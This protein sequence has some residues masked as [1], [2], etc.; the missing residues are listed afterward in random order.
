MAPLRPLLLATALVLAGGP[1]GAQSFDCSKAKGA[2]EAAICA[3]PALAE[4]DRALLDAYRAALAR[5]PARA[6]TIRAE[7]R[8]WAANREAVCASKGEPPPRI[9][10][11]LAGLYR[12]RL[13]T[14]AASAVPPAPAGTPAPPARPAAAGGVPGLAA[15][16]PGPGRPAV[17]PSPAT[18]PRP[19]LVG[20]PVPPLP[21]PPLPALPPR[22]PDPAARLDRDAVA[23][24]GRSDALLTVTSPGR[25]AIRAESRTGVSLQLVDMIAGPGD[26]AGAPGVKDGRVDAL[27]DRGTYKLRVTGAAKAE[28]EA[29]LRVEPFLAAGEA[30]TSLL[31]GGQASTTLADRQSRSFWVAVGASGRVAVEAAGRSLGDLRL[32]RNGRDLADLATRLDRVTPATGHPL[33]RAR[34]EGEVERGLYLATAYGGPKLTWTDGDPGEPLHLRVGAP[35]ALAGLVE[36]TVGPSGTA[37]FAAPSGAASVRLELPEPAAATLRARRGADTRVATL[38]K[39]SREP[40]LALA[41]PGGTGPASLEV[42]AAQG[43]PFRLQALDPGAS[44]RVSG[45]G[46]HWIAVDVAGVGGDEVPATVLLAQSDARAA[47]VI[48]GNAP[49]IGPGQGWRTK[50]NLRGPTTL[51]VEVTGAGPIAV[52]LNGPRSS[53]SFAPLLGSRTPRADGRTPRFDMEPGWYTMKIDPVAGASG[54]ADLT[55]A[56]PGMGVEL[57]AR[58]PPRASVTLGVQ[59]LDRTA[60]YQVFTNAAPGLALAPVARPLPLDLEKGALALDQAAGQAL[61]LPIRWSARG[62]ISALAPNGIPIEATLAYEAASPAGRTATLILPAPD[63]AR[64]VILAWSDPLGAASEVTPI[65]APTELPTVVAGNPRFFNLARGERTSFT[66]DV[67]EG[68]LYRVET[69][70]RLRTALTVATSFLPALDKAEAN[71]AGENALAQTYLRA[72]RYRVV[73]GASESAGRVGLTAR[74]A[75]L[76]EAGRLLPGTSGRAT[77]ADGRGIVFPLEITDAGRYRIELFA[78]GEPF[79]ARIEDHE[80]WPLTAPGPLTSL[81][82]RFE[83]GRYRLVVLPGTVE[84]RAVARL[85]R[86]EPAPELAGHGP[87]PLSFDGEVAFQ[88][89]EPASLGE[90]RHP[91]GWTFRLASPAEVT[92]RLGEGMAGDLRREG[93]AEP[94]ARIVGKPGFAGRLP[95]GRYLLEARALGRNDRLDYTV[96]LAASEIQP[97]VPRRVELPAT[98]S[99]AVAEDRVVTLTTFGRTD[100]KGVLKDQDGRVIER[101]TDR[102]DDWNIGLSRR[103][104]AGSYRLELSAVQPKAKPK[105]EEA[106]SASNDE[107]GDD[108]ESP[109]GADEAA[110]EGAGSDAQPGADAADAPAAAEASPEV[111]DSEAP[112]DDRVEV[113]LALPDAAEMPGLPADGVS[114]AEGG[115]VHLA[116]VPSAEAGTLLLAAARSSQEIVLALERREPGGRWTVVGTSRGLAP[117]VA[118]TADGDASRPWRL[119]AWAVDG[120]PARIA[121]ALRTVRRDSVPA[122]AVALAPVPLGEVAEDVRVA[123][124][125]APASGV[126]SLAE[127]PAGLL[128]GSAAGRAL[129]PAE[130]VLVPQSE[131]VWLVARGPARSLKLAAAPLPTAPVALTVPAGG[132]AVLPHSAPPDGRIR[133]WRAASAFGQ[134]GLEAGRGMGLAAGS[135]VAVAGDAPLRAWNAEGDVPLSLRLVARDLA[136]AP[137]KPASDEVALSVAAGTAQ[138]LRLAAGRK[139]LRLDLAPGTVVALAGPGGAPATV[140]ADR[141]A[142]SRTLEGEWTSLVLAN[143][144][145]SAQPVRASVAPSAADHLALGPETVVKRFFGAA[146]SL[147]LPVDARPGD[148]LVAVGA[149]VSFLGQDGQVLRGR[150]LAL[151]GPGEA[152]LDHPPGLVALWI[153]RAGASPWPKAEPRSVE[154]PSVT[155]LDGPAMTLA[156]APP[157]PVLLH[158]RTSAPAILRLDGGEPAVFPAGAELHRLIPA[159]RS[160]LRLDS[161]HDGPLAGAL[162]LT[163]TPVTPMRDG[164]GEAV[165]LAPGGTALFAFELSRRGPVGIGI[166]AEPDVAAVRLLDAGGRELGRGIAQLHTLDPGRY[167]LEAS[168]PADGRTATL[169]PAVIGIAPPPSGP[170]PDVVAR[171]LELVGLAPTAPSR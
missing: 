82:R 163:A 42:T 128:E 150:S 62:G 52:G 170:P 77:L 108:P 98:I 78:L 129:A 35:E 140:F 16:I 8:S 93:E 6:E 154:L 38:T 117:L 17:A 72:G 27:L 24:A 104:A 58:Q 137:E 4:Q 123:L 50:F 169:R 111:A 134:P 57:P 132:R 89:R 48:A 97:G 122:D 127:A 115:A 60:N 101:L 160:E 161:P 109:E 32:W 166:R 13:G 51:L 49:K 103:L 148:R 46:P 146:G 86:I 141:E 41:L 149:E 11:C 71:G 36:G 63:K 44:R 138:P 100:L 171:Y 45:A 69:L 22:D 10:A 131:A 120:G 18:P 159:G 20:T 164:V 96:A 145:A 158:A 25:F 81:E 76:P 152:I 139:R 31:R 99:F 119:A 135:A 19:V 157:V 65:P 83:P 73:V 113:R 147:S 9:A 23:A 61:E 125:A 12:T 165:A 2:V 167:L 79:R 94:V 53:V 84:A 92:L 168:L 151:A 15:G 70:G 14:L 29:K 66:V 155:K 143:L 114:V 156:L 91:D 90:P 80:G 3:N 116:P 107:S 124:A 54:I 33:T 118:A 1:A 142:V 7:Q 21:V 87:H 26:E 43:Q 67:P 112:A 133:V 153:E 68:G 121:L 85:T 64:A 136:L 74:P 110:A 144:G 95:A 102:A 34:I 126:L 105:P 130:P 59:V 162:E 39:T 56:P 106:E 55:L 40:H 47:R 37:L 88:W 75:E 5:D 30:S 28:G